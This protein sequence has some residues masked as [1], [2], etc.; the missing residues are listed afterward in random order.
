MGTNDGAINSNLE[1]L[2]K[3]ERISAV[4]D[5]LSNQIERVATLEFSR[6]RKSMSV[7]I[8]SPL[9]GG[10]DTLY[11]KGAPESILER[12][13]FVKISDDNVTIPLKPNTREKILQKITQYG[14][15]QSL[16]CIALAKVDNIYAADL[17]L[18][19]QSM[20]INYESNMTFLGIGNFII[21]NI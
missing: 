15:E 6:D 11:V 9:N 20:F 3:D 13:S 18:T 10:T 4:N 8:N 17:D 5:Y 12:C 21:N 16:R 7:I 1:L 19:D 14:K 2:S